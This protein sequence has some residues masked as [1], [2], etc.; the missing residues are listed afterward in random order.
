MSNKKSGLVKSLLKNKKIQIIYTKNQL[1]K[2]RI[3]D[4][5]YKMLG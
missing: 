5:G 4:I 3:K 2:V 1:N